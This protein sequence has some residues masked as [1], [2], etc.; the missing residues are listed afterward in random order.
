M[1]EPGEHTS[2]ALHK[3]ETQVAQKDSKKHSQAQ[4][5]EAHRDRCGEARSGTYCSLDG[6]RGVDNPLSARSS[7]GS[8]DTAQVSVCR[9]CQHL[10]AGSAE[11][12]L[13]PANLEDHLPHPDPTNPRPVSVHRPWAARKYEGLCECNASVS[14]GDCVCPGRTSRGTLQRFLS[15]EAPC[16]RKLKVAGLVFAAIIPWV[17]LVAYIILTYI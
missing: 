13:S 11:V 8:V 14:G 12:V 1:S 3:G 15:C 6:K 2:L 17:F 7:Y 10:Y 4:G 5:M 9:S 16:W